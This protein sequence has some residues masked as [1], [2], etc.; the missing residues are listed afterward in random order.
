MTGGKFDRFKSTYFKKKTK[1]YI[2]WDNFIAQVQ[3]KYIIWRIV[4]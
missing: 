4:S 2:F 1:N 3:Y